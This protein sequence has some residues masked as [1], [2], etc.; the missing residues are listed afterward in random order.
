MKYF[1]F[2]AI[3]IV[4]FVGGAALLV[5]QSIAL[6]AA[7]APLKL[8]IHDE[9]RLICQWE[10]GRAVLQ[11]LHS[12]K[13]C[14]EKRIAKLSDADASVIVKQVWD[15]LD[16]STGAQ[17]A[18]ALGDIL[19]KYGKNAAT[20]FPLNDRFAKN[21]IED[22]CIRLQIWHDNT[23]FPELLAR[24]AFTPHEMD[25][26]RDQ[27]IELGMRKIAVICSW[28]EPT[29]EHTTATSD[30]ILTQMVYSSSYVYVKNDKVTA[31]QN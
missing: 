7:P 31:V 8:E 5:A 21:S 4:R 28:G 29:D 30:G 24:H 23:V 14:G 3:N 20:A 25:L 6:H 15:F 27:Q 19:K 18:D 26:I 13:T 9:L 2:I 10:S 12:I 16:D 22:L 11:Q 17:R 1:Q